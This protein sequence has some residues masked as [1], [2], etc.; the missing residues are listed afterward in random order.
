M[1]GGIEFRKRYLKFSGGHKSGE[2]KKE[3]YL[4]IQ[5]EY[6]EGQNLRAIIDNEKFD[7]AKRV[8]YIKQILEALIYLHDN[9]IIHRDLKPANIFLDKKGE[10]KLGDFGLA[11]VMVKKK[12][13]MPGPLEK[14]YRIPSFIRRMNSNASFTQDDSKTKTAGVGTGHYRSPELKASGKY[15]EKVIRLKQTFMFQTDMY[16][17]GVIIFEMCYP[18]RTGME[19]EEILRALTLNNEFPEDFDARCGAGADLVILGS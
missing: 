11:T 12:E 3:N 4:L 2:H 9:H 10:I 16:S 5:M 1:A 7:E 6:C 13:E 14:L 19:R 8:K 17:L 18:M 15:D